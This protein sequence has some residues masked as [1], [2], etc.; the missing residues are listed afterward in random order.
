MTSTLSNADMIARRLP[1]NGTFNV[2]DVGGYPTQGGG[3]IKW[4]T[5]L[6]ADALHAVDD[7]GR[8]QFSTLGLRTAI[9]LREGDERTSAPSRL[10][11]GVHLVEIPL[12]T[13]AA[14]GEL[15][16]MALQDRSSFRSLEE[17]YEALIAT[18][19]PVLVEVIRQL[20]APG[21]LPALIHCTAG[22]DRTGVVIALVLAALQ[23]PDEVIAIDYAATSIFLGEDFR[24]AY[25]ERSAASGYD[26]ERLAKM[27]ACAPELILKTLQE[28]RAEYGDIAAY[29]EHHGLTSAELATL[30]LALIEDASTDAHD[31]MG[32]AK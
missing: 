14:P 27:L 13:Y 6:R 15:T 12:F 26:G 5:L 16:S 32:G 30:R 9:D 1:I 18:R 23:V 22:K 17:I 28:I 11:E 3:S 29:L 19:G 25:S 20:V 4:R 10:S 31:P 8:A 2:R 24:R 7:D 21:A